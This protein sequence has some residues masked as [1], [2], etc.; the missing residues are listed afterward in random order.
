MLAGCFVD[1][2][3]TG[4]PWYHPPSPENALTAIHSITAALLILIS[5]GNLVLAEGPVTAPTAPAPPPM[6][7]FVFGLITEADGITPIPLV[8][9]ICMPRNN[10]DAAKAGTGTTDK[11]GAFALNHPL[12][13][14]DYT[15]RV[16]VERNMIS[17]QSLTI[18]PD[19]GPT[20]LRLKLPSGEVSG[21][22]FNAAG[23][24]AENA[25]VIL[26]NR[27]SQALY[28]GTTTATGGYH[29][30]H[31]L[32]GTYEASA[33]IKPNETSPDMQMGHTRCAVGDKPVT[34][35]FELKA[36]AARRLTTRPKP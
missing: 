5:F 10:P 1:C 31:V 26:S 16:L 33:S 27:E 15:L 25:R 7:A 8:H 21:T 29:F 32:P 20:A 18:A 14:G 13:P 30:M 23:E 19:T 24:P 12:M 28:S 4:G 36:I 22:V 2:P 6:P 17:L 35:D 11:S 9:V 34:Q 3:A